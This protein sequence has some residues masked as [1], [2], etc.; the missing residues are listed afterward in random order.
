MVRF[1]LYILYKYLV[2]V[3]LT[4]LILFLMH[5][6][7]KFILLHVFILQNVI[8]PGSL[9]RFLL[10]LSKMSL[11]LFILSFLDCFEWAILGPDLLV[12]LF[13]S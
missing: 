3:L 7:H 12:V 6:H 13:F 1:A 11:S 10:C 8:Q 9:I 2:S 5:Q 4:Y